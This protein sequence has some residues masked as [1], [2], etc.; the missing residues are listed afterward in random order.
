MRKKKKVPHN[1]APRCPYCGAVSRLRSA[2]G[3]YF[4]NSKEAMLYVCKNYPACDAYVRVHPGTTI[5]MG[6]L[7]NKKVR[8]LRC[9]AHKHFNKIYLKGIMTREEAYEWL[10]HMLG[11]PIADTHIGQM[12]E[13]YCQKVI[14]ES[15]KLLVSHQ[16]RSF[17]RADEGRLAQCI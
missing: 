10:S 1:C 9:E 3:I 5:P 8:S 4:D 12:G 13:Y 7:A 15:K 17:R 6:T 11:L 16:K 14:E 2:D